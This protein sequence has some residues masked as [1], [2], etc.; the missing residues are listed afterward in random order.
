MK[1]FVALLLDLMYLVA[2]NLKLVFRKALKKAGIFSFGLPPSQK[3]G[4]EG[5]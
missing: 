5:I 4:G 1:I 3:K 2:H